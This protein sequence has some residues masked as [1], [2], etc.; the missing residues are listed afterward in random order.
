MIIGYKDTPTER[1]ANWLSM[2]MLK[3]SEKE[4][5]RLDEQELK[6][7]EHDKKVYRRFLETYVAT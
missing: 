5:N 2:R 4:L 6:I 3:Q 7:A 1:K